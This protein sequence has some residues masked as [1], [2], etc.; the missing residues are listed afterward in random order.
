MMALQNFSHALNHKQWFILI[1]GA[2]RCALLCCHEAKGTG[3]RR[4]SRRREAIKPVG[5]KV[6]Q[7]FF[8]K[9]KGNLI[10]PGVR[11]SIL[12]LKA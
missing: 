6:K 7:K 1:T 9:I 3:E 2:I 8:L 11:F 4:K 12:Q 5:K 10:I